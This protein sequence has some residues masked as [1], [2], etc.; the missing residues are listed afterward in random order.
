MGA[1]STK[2]LNEKKFQI[3]NVIGK[4]S[5]GTVYLVKQKGTKKYFAMKV[6]EKKR[7]LEKNQV[8]H[9]QAE[10]NV[11]KQLNNPFIASLVC[12][13]QN[14]S[15]LFMVIEFVNGGEIYY[16][17]D[18]EQ[19][20]SQSR[21]KLYAAEIILALEHIHSKKIVYRDLKPENILLDSEGHIRLIDFGLSKI[22]HD[23]E[24]GKA[25][26]LCG[27]P[28]YLAPEIL[29]GE[30]QHY[31]VDFWSL[32]VIMFEM[33]HGMPPFYSD[34][35]NDMYIKILTEDLKISDSLDQSTRYVLQGLLD[36]NPATRL[37]LDKKGKLNIK[38]HPFFR[39]IDWD[40]V[41]HKQYI[42]EFIPKVNNTTDLSQIDPK[43]TLEKIDNLEPK[44]AIETDAFKGF[45]FINEEYISQKPKKKRKGGIRL[46]ACTRVSDDDD[47]EKG[48][49]TDSDEKEKEK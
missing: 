32:G 2:K 18:R 17:L 45:S 38:K 1:N 49:D 22:L 33:L 31:A 41:Y 29:T 40:K 28:E 36:R 39:G 23:G 5:F 37:G 9:L 26:T 12:S 11:H 7:I 35:S 4:G 21:V 43:F 20:F 42:P 27:T 48:K 6:L 25:K 19:V 3:L 24:D 16:H 34:N 46:R 8:K 10:R 47:D 44:E 13:F 15:Q 30:E 14:E